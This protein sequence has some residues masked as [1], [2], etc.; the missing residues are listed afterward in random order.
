MANLFQSNIWLRYFLQIVCTALIYFGLATLSL[1]LQFQNSN[2]TPVWPPSGFAFAIILLWGYRIAPGILFGAF[3]ANLFIFITNQTVDY[4]IAIVLSMFIGLGNML[5]AMAGNYLLRKFIPDFS[6]DRFFNRTS[7]IFHFALTAGLMCIVSSTIGSFSVYFAGII[8]L[9][10]VSTV[11]I[12]WWLG[13]FSGIVLLTTFIVIW[14]SHLRQ[15][16]LQQD[17]LFKDIE[18]TLLFFALILI[19]GTVF[20]NWFF[21]YSTFNYPY[22]IIPIFAWAALRFDQRV[23]ITAIVICST[24]ATLGTIHHK[25]PFGQLPLN[26][27]LISLQSFICIMVLTKLAMNVSVIQRR[28]SEED[29]RNTGVILEERVKSRTAQLETQEQE[30]REQKVF[31]ELLIES[32]PYMI[33]AYDKDF[34]ITAWNKKSE[35][36]SGLTKEQV[37]GKSMLELL[38]TFES[39]G[40]KARLGEVLEEGKSLHFP[41]YRFTQKD[42]WGES[43][44]T[45]LLNTQNEIIGV[46]TITRDITELVNVTQDLEQK[47]LDLMK[48]NQEL[49]SFA[50]VASH[51]LQEPLRKIQMFSKRIIDTDE[52]LLS[53]GSRDYFTRMKNA[54]QRMQQLIEDLLMYSRTGNLARNFE[55]ADLNEVLEEVKDEL[56]DEISQK[57]VIIETNGLSSCRIIRF[58]FRQLLNNL[59]SNSIKFS[60]DGQVIRIVVES[61]PGKGKDF[62][63][64][65]LHPEKEYCHVRVS[66][67][68]IG[69]APEF[70]E[71]IF[72][73]FQRLH[74]KNEYP[75]TGIG[76]AICKK[77]VENHHGFI[78][79]TGEIGKGATFDIYIPN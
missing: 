75:G 40:W 50:Y 10:Q 18:V 64:K 26:E 30:I 22:W 24:M 12:T 17:F 28:K 71:Q 55:T 45:P 41:R 34:R 73:L 70:S 42:G 59:I 47:N 77:I 61:K 7:Q 15:P 36:H 78:S 14:V 5:E 16:L 62:S 69:F 6:I 9:S 48:T 76:L 67:N 44:M 33:L 3:A 65:S 66:D 19:T 53:E 49:S 25:G 72:G 46:L 56:K 27:A 79:A 38:P 39:A 52:D 32:S 68:G 29:L 4:P 58:Q 31:A 57:K 23:T 60:K 11:F 1:T 13:D 54:A 21:H 2:A 37:F 35:E 74:G 51:D 63:H 20:N 43:F 8:P